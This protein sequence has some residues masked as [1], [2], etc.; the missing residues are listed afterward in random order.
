MTNIALEQEIEWATL[1][2][3][4]GKILGINNKSISD[5]TKSLAYKNIYS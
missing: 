4:G 1:M 5:Y 2:Y 3:G